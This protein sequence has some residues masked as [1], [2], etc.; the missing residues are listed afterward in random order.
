MNTLEIV[1]ALVVAVL[2]GGG[3]FG[4]IVKLRGQRVLTTD[5]WVRGRVDKLE[6]RLDQA[7]DDCNAKLEALKAEHDKER[8]ADGRLRHAIRNELMACEE[9]R[10]RQDERITWLDRELRKLRSLLR[11][12]DD[13]PA[14]GVDT[15]TTKEK[16]PR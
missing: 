12:E 15:V 2:G 11:L 9:G 5:Q 4:A 1:A 3:V 14:F 6:K 10:A 8:E 16:K 13:S 7:D